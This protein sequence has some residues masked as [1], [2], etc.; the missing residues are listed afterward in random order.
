M[1]RTTLTLL[2]ITALSSLAGAAQG[3][4]MRVVESNEP[5][6][7]LSGP[8]AEPIVH[9]VRTGDTLWDLSDAYYGTP[10]YWPTVWSQN[11]QISNPHYI[12]P[13]DQIRFQA[14]GAEIPTERMTVKDQREKMAPGEPAVGGARVRFVP[15]EWE[16]QVYVRHVGFLTDEE[17]RAAGKVRHSRE[18]REMLGELD[19]VYID[20]ER[21]P[22]VRPGDRWTLLSLK[23]E[24]VH[25]IYGRKMGTKVEILGVIDIRA[26]SRK[27]AMGVIVRSYKEIRRGALVVPLVPNF[28]SV[29]PR[30]NTKSVRGYV[31]DSFHE[32]DNIGQHDFVYVDKGQREGVEVG[33]RFH[34]VRRG[35]GLETVSG[36]D[37]DRLPWEPIGEIMVVESQEHHCTGVVLGDFTEILVGDVVEL[38]PGF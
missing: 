37:L 2:L 3:Q 31:V 26:V 17:V 7:R 6:G 36:D 11:P 21:L 16:H 30:P 15:R 23:E 18:E 33:N 22:R 5:G 38:R 1:R 29:K 28:R 19:E 13:G 12:Y 8:D 34:V 24:L 20:F 25:P 27:V 10:W 9:E 35:D 32:L 14:T 4:D